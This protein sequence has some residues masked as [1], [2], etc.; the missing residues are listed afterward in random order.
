LVTTR[1]RWQVHAAN[2]LR[3]AANLSSISDAPFAAGSPVA[4]ASLQNLRSAI[5]EARVALGA[6]PYAFTAVIS[7]GLPL[8]AVDIQEF[9]EA[10]R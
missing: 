9:R 8:R 2:I 4:A 7:S 10:V 5:N 6:V 1:L 3:S